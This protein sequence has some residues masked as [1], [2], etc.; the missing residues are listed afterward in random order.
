ML[1]FITAHGIGSITPA[2]ME[3]SCFL[4]TLGVCN[5]GER[6]TFVATAHSVT[7]SQSTDRTTIIHSTVGPPVHSVGWPVFLKTKNIFIFAKI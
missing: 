4:S 3:E 2:H 6:C 5:H 7:P 1:S